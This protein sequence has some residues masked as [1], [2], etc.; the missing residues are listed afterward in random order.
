MTIHTEDQLQEPQAEPKATPAKRPARTAKTAPAGESQPKP[1]L[2]KPQGGN[3]AVLPKAQIPQYPAFCRGTSQY[4]HAFNTFGRY[5]K[6][7]Q[8]P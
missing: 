2:L 3:C 7:Q 8:N 6:M 5:T 1:R 4:F